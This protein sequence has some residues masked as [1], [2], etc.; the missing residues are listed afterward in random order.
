MSFQPPA[1][2][3]ARQ[4]QQ[5]QPSNGGSSL[6]NANSLM[7]PKDHTERTDDSSVIDE[8]PPSLMTGT[9]TYRMSVF[10]NDGDW[11][12]DRRN[13]ETPSGRSVLVVKRR[14]QRPMPKR[15]I[16]AHKEDSIFFDDQEVVLRNSMMGRQDLQTND[17]TG[18]LGGAWRGVLKRLLL[19]T[20]DPVNA[21]QLGRILQLS[22]PFLTAYE[23]Y[24]LSNVIESLDR[25]NYERLSYALDLA[26]M[27]RNVSRIMVQNVGA[28]YDFWWHWSTAVS[29]NRFF[30]ALGQFPIIGITRFPA[31]ENFPSTRNHA[32]AS[33]FRVLLGEGNWI[34]RVVTGGREGLVTDN[35]NNLAQNLA[36]ESNG[37]ELA[38]RN[39]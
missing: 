10:A 36:A 21:R 1:D 30:D 33:I 25:R 31:T 29:R 13:I 11:T 23:S 35:P 9:Q 18:L 7:D 32:L 2:D 38:N 28:R 20:F 6:S 12:A 4:N 15:S 26:F 27:N 3:A 37:F 22:L 17:E 16:D 19:Y 8:R 24:I 34:T 14:R 5:Q 39:Q